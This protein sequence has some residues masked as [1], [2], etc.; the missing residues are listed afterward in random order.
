MTDN[1]FFWP[2]AIHELRN[3]LNVIQLV[4][5]RLNDS[6]Y[7]LD[8]SKRDRYLQRAQA[9]TTQMERLLG[10]LALLEELNRPEF[11]VKNDRHSLASLVETYQCYGAATSRLQSYNHCPQGKDWIGDQE[12]LK[13]ILEP[14]LDN[15]LIHSTGPVE[16]IW[17]QDK[18]QQ[19]L[20]IEIHDQGPGIPKA[21]QARLYV[22][23]YRGQPSKTDLSGAQ[24]GT[25]LGLTLVQAALHLCAGQIDLHNLT[26]SGSCFR[27]RLPQSIG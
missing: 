22:P 13:H 17:Q 11:V 15:A 5:D 18:D 27:V 4:L 21:E 20:I 24:F 2:Q 9:C 8:D 7:P 16:I 12:L 3:P 6:T 14:I 19:A 1:H 26:P 23:F 25:G 10:Q